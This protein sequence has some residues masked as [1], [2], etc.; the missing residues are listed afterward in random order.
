MV[1]TSAPSLRPAI[2]NEPCV[3]VEFSKNRFTSVL[4]GECVGVLHALAVELD[5]A[6]AQFQQCLDVEPVQALDTQRCRWGK[7]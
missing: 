5:I 3:R 4:T 7:A 1:T 2:S 6:V